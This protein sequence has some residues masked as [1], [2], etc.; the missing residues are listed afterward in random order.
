MFRYF[1]APYLKNTESSLGAVK[2]ERKWGW[3][4]GKQRFKQAMPAGLADFSDHASGS[5]IWNAS[6][7]RLR[8]REGDMHRR[9]GDGEGR[10]GRKEG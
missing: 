10:L 7:V 8:G 6:L 1:A 4:E 5:I 9:R 3:T 2:R